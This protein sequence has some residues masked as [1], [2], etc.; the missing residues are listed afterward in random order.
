MISRNLIVA[1]TA[2]CLLGNGW[3]SDS[4]VKKPAPKPVTQ[5]TPKTIPAPK[6]VTPAEKEEASR[7]E[8]MNL[9]ARLAR[10]GRATKNPVLMVAAADIYARIPTRAAGEQA[11]EEMPGAK[12][13]QK[14]LDEALKLAPE[15]PAVL[16]PARLVEDRLN[17]PTRAPV[18]WRLPVF[19]RSS[20]V[21]KGR[22]STQVLFAGK[23]TAKV[24]VLMDADNP[25]TVAVYDS[26]NRVVW[27]KE[28]AAEDGYAYAQFVPQR[29]ER[30]TIWIVNHG[31][32]PAKF[33]M[34]AY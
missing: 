18:G 15:D 4:A 19:A 10:Y 27:H 21:A 29:N 16:E 12:E 24:S 6:A 17:S 33:S 2:T 32:T 11:V 26:S 20:V 31:Q 7:F 5:V 30:F 25:V 22:W 8:A 9:A 3:T 34:T 13:A 28:D 1:A 14:L 23:K